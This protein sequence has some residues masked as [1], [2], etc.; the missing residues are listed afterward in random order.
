DGQRTAQLLASLLRVLLDEIDHPVHERV[1]EPLLDSAFTPAQVPFSPCT[2]TADRASEL[3]QPLGGVGP[4]VEDHVLHQLG[5][6][7]WNVLVDGELTGIDDAHVQPRLDRVEQKGRVDG[8]PYPV[9][10]PEREGE[11]RYAA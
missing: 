5:Q 9:I 2:L 8:L 3:H 6:V 11:V 1:G 4:A 7:G 10:A